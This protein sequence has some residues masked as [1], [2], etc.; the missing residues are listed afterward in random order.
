MGEEVGDL[1]GAKF[2][3]ANG[4]GADTQ[5][6]VFARAVAPASFQRRTDSK[7]DPISIGMNERHQIIS[8]DEMRLY[9]SAQPE[10]KSTQNPLTSIERFRR[11]SDDRR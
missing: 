10:E 11:T 2:Q 1:R 7:L 8:G 6:V 4:A 5:I 9:E 3:S